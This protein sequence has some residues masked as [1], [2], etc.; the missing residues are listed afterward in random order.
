MENQPRNLWWGPPRNFDDR[1]HER[2][3]SWL[4]LFYDLVYVAAIGQLTH[5]I[6]IHPSWEIIVFSFLLFC[7]LF[8][9]W[10]NGS[11]YYDLHGNDSI[12]T[13]LM[14]FWQ[15]LAVAAVAIT[16]PD[17]FHG[18]TD[19]FAIAFCAI[20]IMITYLWWSVGF[21]DPSHRVFSRWFTTNYCIAFLLLVVSIFAPDDIVIPLWITVLL[22][23][24]T[25]PLIGARRMIKVLAER[26]QVFTASATIV[27]RFG[28]FTI[29]VLA[30]SILSTV[31]SIIEIEDRNATIWFSFVLCIFISFLIWSIYFDMTSEQETKTGYFFMQWFI[32]L[33]FPLLASLSV[34]GACLKSLLIHAEHMTTVYWIFCTAIV[35]ILICIVLIAKVMKE[36]EED[37]AYIAPVS[38]IMLIT[39]V[40]IMI[41]PL[42][43]SKLNPLQFL[44]IISAILFGPVFIGIRSW[45][46]YKFYNDQKPQQVEKLTE[47][48]Y[49]D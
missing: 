25:P 24:V 31:T 43:G 49:E 37:R 19:G 14:T 7:M 13:R 3:I 42:F 30:E 6:A 35:M 40:A 45:V 16:I 9:S 32:F 4:E 39:C 23:N 47:D 21:Y 15:M 36:E 26:G 18:N 44:G 29:I 1:K 10:V 5:H 34:V 8:W 48:E 41:V 11:Q 17:A 33:H 2:K 22:L 46:I 38:R 27:E 20:Q 28:L 12:R